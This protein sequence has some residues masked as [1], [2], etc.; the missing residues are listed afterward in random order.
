V[1]LAPAGAGAALS[2]WTWSDGGTAV[3]PLQRYLGHAM[4]L[5]HL[6]RVWDEGRPTRAFRER[7]DRRAAALADGLARVGLLGSWDRGDEETTPTGLD[8]LAQLSSALRVDRF[9]LVNVTTSIIEMRRGAEIAG[10]NMRTALKHVVPV[11]HHPDDPFGD[12]AGLVTH[13][14]E[15]LDDELVFLGTV[16]SRARATTEVADRLGLQHTLTSDLQLSA[17][18]R[19]RLGVVFADLFPPGPHADLVLRNIGVPPSRLPS[20]IG[21]RAD[22]WWLTVFTEFENGA[23]DSPYRR[24]LLAG[25]ADYPRNSV[26]MQI[27]HRHGLTWVTRQVGSEASVSPER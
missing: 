16:D 9:H 22:T 21:I 26:L 8:D 7:I 25:L 4:K 14:L 11:P 23:G 6:S 2:A 10:A 18:E 15:R 27:A 17:E 1:V 5:R 19:S 13:L 20:P 12:D 3:S 24:L